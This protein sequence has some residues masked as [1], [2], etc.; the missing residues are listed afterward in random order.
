MKFWNDVYNDFFVIIIKF[1]QE[2][3]ILKL[4]EICLMIIKFMNTRP[5]YKRRFFNVF[6]YIRKDCFRHTK[7]IKLKSL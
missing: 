7:V 4:I 5:Y 3:F 6:I 2:K 1:V